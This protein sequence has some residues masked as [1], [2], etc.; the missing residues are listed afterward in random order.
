MKSLL[1]LMLCLGLGL[2]MVPAQAATIVGPDTF[3]TGETYTPW[4][5]GELPS[6]CWYISSLVYTEEA[7][8]I[9]GDLVVF[10]D[11]PTGGMCLG[12]STQW[13]DYPEFVFNYPGTWTIR[14]VQHHQ[15]PALPDYPDIVTEKEVIVTGPVAAQSVSF[16][17]VKALYR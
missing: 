11:N 7:F 4:I 14:L 17:A 2:T 6:S 1:A 3:G 10:Y 5:F 16:S 8:L 9:T 15:H 12:P 13:E